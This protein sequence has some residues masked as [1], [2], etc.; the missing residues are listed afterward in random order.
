MPGLN[1]PRRASVRP[2]SSIRQPQDYGGMNWPGRDPGMRATPGKL[3]GG[4]HPE[5][6]NPR[7]TFLYA[8]EVV[9]QKPPGVKRI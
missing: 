8:T 9:R 2:P 6:E 5:A 1:T 3:G 4:G 7:A